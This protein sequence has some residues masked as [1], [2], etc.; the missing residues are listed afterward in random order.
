MADPK[1]LVLDLDGTA[2]NADRRLAA[3]DVEAARRLRSAGVHVTIATGRIFTGT[4]RVARELG[5]R[6]PVA[7]MNGCEILDAES[8]ATLF[9]AYVRPDAHRAI[10]G[11]LYAHGLSPFLFESRTIHFG[12]P[13]DQHFSASGG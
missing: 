1:L 12:S 10:R 13:D 7:V 6:G 5:V 8:G 4:Q 11:V 3:V 2:L 9:G